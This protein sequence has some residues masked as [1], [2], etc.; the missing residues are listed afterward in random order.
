MKFQKIAFA[1]L[2]MAALGAAQAGDLTLNQTE[3][4]ENTT[5]FSGGRVNAGNDDYL[6]LSTFSAFGSNGPTASAT[7]Q[8]GAGFVLNDLSLSFDYKSLGGLNPT[9]SSVSLIGGAFNYSTLLDFTSS[10]VAGQPV[11]NA[12]KATAFLLSNPNGSSNLT[13][14]GLGTLAAGTY[15]LTFTAGNIAGLKVDDVKIG[16]TLAAVPEPETYALMLAGLAAVSFVARRRKQ[17]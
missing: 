1:V 6:W 4:F 11:L 14:S 12:A 9:K 2:T 5:V 3:T 10:Y 7:F 17:A 8:V 13:L 16:G 15:T